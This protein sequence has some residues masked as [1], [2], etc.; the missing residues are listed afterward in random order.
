[1]EGAAGFAAFVPRSRRALVTRAVVAF[2]ATYN[3]LDVLAEQPHSDPVTN[4]YRLHEALLSALDPERSASD[5]YAHYPGFRD[6]G[7]LQEMIEA[8]RDA[9]A[10]LPSFS[11]AA[12]AALRAAERIAVFQS[13]NLSKLQGGDEQLAE[14]AR[15]QTPEGSELRWWET[16]GSGGSSMGVYALIAAAARSDLRQTE[17][18][19]IENAYFPWIGSLH[20]LMDSLVDFDEDGVLEQRNLVDYYDSVQQAAQRMRMI[21]LRAS[22]STRSLPHGRYHAIILAGMIGYYLSAR[23]ASTPRALPITESVGDTLGIL[24]K[25]T[26]MVFRL[27]NL[28]SRAAVFST[29]R[30]ERT[31]PVPTP[32][33]RP[34]ALA[35]N[36]K[37]PA[38]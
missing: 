34:H 13:L 30:P 12:P 28:A 23:E 10:E 29:P 26:L 25:P 6:N 21:A 27:R 22:S 15:T 9:L 38:G 16:A 36:D 2:Q 7:Y 32:A 35:G 19:G 11:L 37:R 1:M 24:A 4:G 33:H 5:Y 14:W 3:Y 31:T 17:V 8:C 20:S 18:E